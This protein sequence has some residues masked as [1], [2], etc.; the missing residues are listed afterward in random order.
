MANLTAQQAR[1]L[2][3]SFYELSKKLGD[4]RFGNWDNLT[5]S[6]RTKLENIQWTLMN[7][8]SDFTAVAI[9]QTVAELQNT[10]KN[11]SDATDKMK[12]AIGNIQSIDKILKVA[13]AAVTLGASIAT[14]N[15]IAIVKG[16]EGVADA[17]SGN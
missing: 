4:Y 10:L 11:I 12:K 15:P 9:S 6:Q 2:A 5:P 16:L 17:L 14:G 8:S 13:A 3:N 1:D 7:Y